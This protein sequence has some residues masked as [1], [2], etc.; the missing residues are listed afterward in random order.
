M[1]VPS[2][3]AS[4]STTPLRHE[5]NA[6][7]VPHIFKPEIKRGEWSLSPPDVSIPGQ[8][9]VVTTGYKAGK[10]PEPLHMLWQSK[11]NLQALRVSP[12]CNHG[13]VFRN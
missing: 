10:T 8:E 13:F 6:G 12:W 5:E 9:T 3:C 2:P 4:L 1:T 11:I 7:I